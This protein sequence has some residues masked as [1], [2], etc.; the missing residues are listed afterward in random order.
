LR[1][2]TKKT[3][4]DDDAKKEKRKERDKK[5]TIFVVARG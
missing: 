1:D 4:K 3:I 5:S 2:D